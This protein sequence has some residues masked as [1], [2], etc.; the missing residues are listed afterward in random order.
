MLGGGSLI[1][2]IT[3][4]IIQSVLYEDPGWTPPIL[5]ILK[6]LPHLALAKIEIPPPLLQPHIPLLSI[7]LQFH[8]YRTHLLRLPMIVSP[9]SKLTPLLPL[10]IRLVPSLIQLVLTKVILV[11]YSM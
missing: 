6:L 1:V 10:V 8:C 4:N 3:Q 2:S 7:Q 9:P 11:P 5:L